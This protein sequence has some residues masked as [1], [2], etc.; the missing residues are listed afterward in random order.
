MNELEIAEMRIGE[1]VSN[2]ELFK[3]IGRNSAEQ[4]VEYSKQSTRNEPDDFKTTSVRISEKKLLVLD[5]VMSKFGVTRT[6]AF[7]YAV[8]QIIVDAVIGYSVGYADY[9]DGNEQF[10]IDRYEAFVQSLPLD[11]DL[12]DYVKNMVH[13]EFVEYLGLK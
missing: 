1:P 3:F 4:D 12:K 6:D 8:T 10:A 9:F 11:D 5:A 13:N 7:S 2:L